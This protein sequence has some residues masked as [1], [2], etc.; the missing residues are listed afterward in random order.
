MHN[1][2]SLEMLKE[3]CK[4]DGVQSELI[5]EYKDLHFHGKGI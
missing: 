2:L 4:Y 5:K 1:N 3:I